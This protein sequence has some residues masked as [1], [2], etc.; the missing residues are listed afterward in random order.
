MKSLREKNVN[1]P[2]LMLT[3]RDTKQDIMTGLNLGADDYLIKP[4]SFGELIARINAVLRRPNL[5]L[6]NF[7]WSD[8]TI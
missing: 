7:K 4:F 1:I 2:I 8:I 6:L 5:G 3:T